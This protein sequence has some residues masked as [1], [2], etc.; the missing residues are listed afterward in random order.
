MIFAQD[1]ITKHN[2]DL[3]F[4]ELG[5]SGEAELDKKKSSIR[6]KIK[7]A[8]IIASEH[9]EANQLDPKN[10]YASMAEAVNPIK[11]TEE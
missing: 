1:F 9:S 10:E 2:F 11:A 5:Y 8:T 3:R 7:N 4:G 6:Y